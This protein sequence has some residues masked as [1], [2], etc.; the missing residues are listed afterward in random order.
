VLG[1]LRELTGNWTSS[2]W[3]L[4]LTAV[5]AMLSG[6]VIARQ[7]TIDQELEENS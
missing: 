5:P 6:T 3:F 4:L 7:K 2:L 1:I